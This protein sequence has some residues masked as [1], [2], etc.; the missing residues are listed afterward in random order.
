[1][2]SSTV[3]ASAALS[4]TRLAQIS[5]PPGPEIQAGLGWASRNS[6]NRAA[7]GSPAP[8]ETDSRSHA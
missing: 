5:R 2:A 1:M 3:S 8:V 6:E 4:Q 7:D